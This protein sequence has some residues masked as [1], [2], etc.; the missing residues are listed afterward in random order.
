[1]TAPLED[2]Y[3]A[4]RAAWAWL[5][6]RIWATHVATARA[7]LRALFRPALVAFIALF[8]LTLP[9]AHLH[10]PID[11]PEPH[12]QMRSVV[13][14]WPVTGAQRHIAVHWHGLRCS[15]QSWQ[16][17][18]LPPIITRIRLVVR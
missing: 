5:L 12:N 10:G 14:P 1:M 11:W 18:S 16:P 9:T 8:T 7:L 2:A 4:D 6:G 15:M 3:R 17:D 13:R